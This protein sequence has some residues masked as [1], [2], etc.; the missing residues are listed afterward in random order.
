[1]NPKRAKRGL[2]RIPPGFRKCVAE[3]EACPR[4][5]SLAAALAILTAS[6]LC[7]QTEWPSYGHDLGSTRYS[8]VAQINT[9]NVSKL[10]RVWT[11]HQN[12][13]ALPTPAVVTSTARVNVQ[14]PP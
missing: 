8:P 5:A 4:F 14:M 12:P 1:M 9:S 3:S 13:D 11:F 7:G 2:A 10:V 6:Q